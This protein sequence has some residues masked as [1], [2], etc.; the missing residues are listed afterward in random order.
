MTTV[1]VLGLGAMGLPM[2]TRLSET[3]GVTGY[4]VDPERVKLAPSVKASA[5][6]AEACDGADVVVVSVR[7]GHQ[8]HDA[9]F[10]EH[11]AVETL[12]AHSV[13][14]L[15]ST[16]GTDSAREAAAKLNKCEVGLVDAPVSGGAVRAG[17]GDL[18]LMVSGS[19][20]DLAKADEVL[21]KLGSK[22]VVAGN[23]I[24]D[25]QNM[26]TVNQLLAGIHT[27]AANEALA[28][29]HAL[30]L[31]L[32][33]LIEVLGTGAAASFMLADRGP[34]I[35]Q[36]LQGVEPPLRS[37]LDIINKDMGI[38]TQLA[39]SVGVATP[40]AAAA[41]QLYLT[42]MSRGLAAKDDSVVSTILA[43]E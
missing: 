24:G 18:L 16:V 40:V 29:A 23:S 27:A 32:E 1:A 10:G 5:S 21:H 38:V 17:K 42:A 41:G 12:P 15:T 36:Q 14:I 6:P 39:R 26:K 22:V 4:D 13:V 25:G 37:R 7:D 31:E 8:L 35:A 2:A 9:L 11:G 30:G 20:D 19:E 28:L 43:Q 3:M 33:P 34:R